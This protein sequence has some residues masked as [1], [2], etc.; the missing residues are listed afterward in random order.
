[1]S[2]EDARIAVDC[3]ADGVW[4]SNHGAR[5]LD[6]CRSTAETLPGIRAALGPDI[7]IIVESGP[8]T[9]LDIARMLAL[10]A[11]FVMLVRA[12]IFAVAVLG[13]RGGDQAA[14]Q[15]RVTTPF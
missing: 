15:P 6:A 4:V 3:E 9:G 13:T 11:D 8:R 7:P 2:T 14:R 10:G 5:Q 12:F 1:M